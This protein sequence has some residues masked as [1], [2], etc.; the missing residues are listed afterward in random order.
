VRGGEPLFTLHTD[1]PD[2]FAGAQDVL[3]EAVSVVPEGSRPDVPP[4]VLDRIAE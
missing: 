1:E 3:A 4:L 2:R